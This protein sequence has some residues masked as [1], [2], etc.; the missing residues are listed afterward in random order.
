[1]GELSP[2]HLL[3]LAVAFALLFRAN[4]LPEAAR[5]LGR[6]LRIFKAETQG[7]REDATAAAPSAVAPAPVAPVAPPP[8]PAYQPVGPPAATAYAPVTAPGGSGPGGFP[9]APPPV[10]ATPPVPAA[11]A[12]VPQVDPAAFPPV[13][14][15]LV[16]PESPVS[17]ANPAP[18]TGP[19]ASG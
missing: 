4:K 19:G 10:G 7:L 13:T 18:V 17:G 8:V 11:T 12:P 5:S 9:P 1:M 2:W 6:S 14:A 3:I 15:Q 16:A